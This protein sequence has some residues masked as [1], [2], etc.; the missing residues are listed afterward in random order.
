[1]QQEEDSANFS[2][3]S[4][5]MTSATPQAQ[6]CQ[7]DLKLQTDLSILNGTILDAAVGTD[8]ALEFDETSYS[9]YL[10]SLIDRK[11]VV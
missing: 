1:M 7:G 10:L 8:T 9:N 4:Q 3:D 2:S 6:C 11:S 5:Q